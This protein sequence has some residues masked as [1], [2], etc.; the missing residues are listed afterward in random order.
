MKRLFVFPFILLAFFLLS[1]CSMK[2][3]A[4]GEFDEIIVFADSVDWPEYK[5]ILLDIFAKE[6]K[7]PA[8]EPEYIVRWRPFRLFPQYKKRRNIF[9]LARL[10]SDLPVSSEVKSSLSKD[11]LQGIRKGQYF[12]IPKKDIWAKEQYVLFLVAPNRNAMIQQLYDYADALYKDFEHSYYVRLKNFLYHRFENKKLEQYLRAHFPFTLRVQHDY[13]V[14]DESLTEGYVWLRRLDPDRSMFV[15]WV[16]LTDTLKVTPR[17]I[18]NERNRIAAKIYE[19]DVI[20]EEETHGRQIRFKNWPA[21]RLEGTWK[22]PKYVIGGPFRNITFIDRKNGY[23]FMIDYYVQ[24]IGRR[25]KI[26]L[27]QLEV[28]A[29]TFHENLN[30]TPKS[31]ERSR[32]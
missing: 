21:Y 14:A 15:H 17:W 8:V 1:R 4:Q 11:V 32:G 19:G 20:V 27:D 18:I 24:A 23:V 7:T 12:Y 3:E 2:M 16:P 22:N 5:D 28:M 30:K 29:Y 13:F 6:Y 31:Q 10:D 9:L 26:F 25:K